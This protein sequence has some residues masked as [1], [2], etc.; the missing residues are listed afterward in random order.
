MK[1]FK[2]PERRRSRG[3]YRKR[4]IASPPRFS[5]YKPSG[6]PRTKLEQTVI[7]LD[8][9]EAFRLA[10]HQ[11]H[12]HLEA[13]A[14]MEISRP[15]FSRLIEKARSKIAHAIV[16]GLE[17]VIEGGNINFSQGM[18]R[19]RDCGDEQV[20][21]INETINDC[22]ECGSEDIEDL[23]SKYLTPEKV[24]QEEAS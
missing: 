23:A 12:D 19:C 21:A 5:N 6:I 2:Q 8:E 10:D 20:H 14:Q 4:R 9:Y 15:T 18:H 24:E 17:L 22:P 11:G 7:T 1:N 16:D 3:A 13:S